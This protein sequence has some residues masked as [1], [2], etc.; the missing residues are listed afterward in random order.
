MVWNYAKK[1]ELLS[2]QKTYRLSSFAHASQIP[3]FQQCSANDFISKPFDL[4]D[5]LFRS[6][7][8]NITLVSISPTS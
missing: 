6:E 4:N 3:V 7:T 1:S 2:K 5:I 8:D